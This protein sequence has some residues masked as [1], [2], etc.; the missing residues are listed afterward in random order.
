MVVWQGPDADLTGI[1]ARRFNADGTPIDATEFQV[2]SFTDLAQFSP[3]VSINAN[4]QFVVAWVS[5]HPAVSDPI[6]NEKSIFVQA[7]DAVAGDVGTRDS[8]S[9]VREGRTG[10]SGY[11]H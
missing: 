2:N 4:H 1:Y 7:Y 10:T 11:R 8:G 5:D 9:P 3:A 6:D